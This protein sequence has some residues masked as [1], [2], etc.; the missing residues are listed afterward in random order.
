MAHMALVG[1]AGQAAG[2]GQH[3]QQ[4]HFGQAHGAGAVVNQN[5]FVASQRQLVAAT[6]ASAI[7]R[8]KELQ[9][10]VGGGVFQSVARLVG[11][12][13]EVHLPGVAADAQHENV[14]AGAEHLLLGA[15]HDHGAHFR[16]FKANALN[17]VVQLDVDTEVV[18]VE[19]ELVAR[20]Q[21]GVFVKIRLQRGDSAIELKLP[22]FVLGRGGLVFDTAGNAHGLLSLI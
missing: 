20:T 17:S 2:A 4:R 18:A 21:A 1:D 15:G 7:N 22:V 10:A 14:G 9:A 11:E 16:V 13:A 5:D 3:A 12:F 8:G 6:S 19:L